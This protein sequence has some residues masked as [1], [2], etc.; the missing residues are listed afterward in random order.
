MRSAPMARARRS[1]RGVPSYQ[2]SGL[3]AGALARPF[4]GACGRGARAPGPLRAAFIATDGTGMGPPPGDLG[5]LA[6][7]W[8]SASPLQPLGVL[9]GLGQ[10]QV[11]AIAPPDLPAD[12]RPPRPPAAGRL[13]APGARPGRSGQA[14]PGQ[15]LLMGRLGRSGRGWGV[16]ARGPAIAGPV[17]AVAGPGP[18]WGPVARAPC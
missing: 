15:P 4:R 16:C 2:P 3:A 10:D 5:H 12:R 17:V 8:T 7:S 9:G 6:L 14:G 13:Q 11:Q 18:R 1:A